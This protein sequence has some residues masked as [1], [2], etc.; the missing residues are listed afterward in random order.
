MSEECPGHASAIL[1]S[2]KQRLHFIVAAQECNKEISRPVLEDEA[3]REAAAIFEQLC[4]QLANADAAVGVGLAEAFGKLAQCE[5]AL[6]FLALGQFPQPLQHARGNG[7]RPS[8]S[9]SSALRL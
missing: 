3:Q 4:A 9:A 1:A 5:Q 8:Q 6:Y 2:P 7:E